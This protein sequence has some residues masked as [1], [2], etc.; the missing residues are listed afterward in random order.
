MKELEYPFDAEYIMQKKKKIK[1]ELLASRTNFLEKNIAILGG[2]TTN[3]IKLTLELFLLNY[4]I[5]PNFYESEYGKYY[6]DALFG[7]DELD[8]FKPDI[9]FIHTTNRNIKEY[10]QISDSLAVVEDKLATTYAEFEQVW[11]AL[12]Q[13]FHCVIIQNNFEY[14]SYRLLG[15]REAT[16]IHG[17]IHFIN[18]LNMMFAEYAEAHDDFFI[19]DILY[20]SSVL[21]LDNWADDFYWYMYKYA[22][23]FTAIP[24]LSYNVANI[25]KAI[26][27]MNQKALVLDLDNT[28][29][30]GVVG[31]D[32]VENLLIGKETSEGQAYTAFQEYI[33]AQKQL[34]VLLCVN[35]KNDMKNALAGLN[36]PEGTLNES[37]FVLI[38]ANWEN[39]AQNLKEIAEELNLG[40]DSLVFV[41]DN[42]AERAIINQSYEQVKTPNIGDRI[43]NYIKSIDRCGF[44]ENIR[45]SEDDLKKSD[46]Y[47]QNAQRTKAIASF[48]NY[49][50]YLK[51]LEMNAVVAPFSPIYMQRIAQLTNK[52]NQFNLTTKRYTQSEIEEVANDRQFIT[53]YG[54]L[55]DKFGDNGVVSVVIRT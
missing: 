55:S 25:I 52:S 12:H 26:Y 54:K 39:K 40:I 21:G 45:I 20:E 53:L 28:L 15:N 32:G 34:G 44:F 5:K 3:D 17:R 2:S 48:T 27:G 10:P 6:E 11:E 7:N 37:D 50:D 47:R 33:K 30:G 8:H 46:M 23:S 18:Q 16:D 14:P 41:D 42:P 24:Y 13:K 22:L 43:E 49:D 31:D 9:I 4:G 1:K 51:S 36:H 29:W 38:K 19:N 35:S